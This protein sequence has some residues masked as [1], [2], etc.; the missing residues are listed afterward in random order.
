LYYTRAC[1]LQCYIHLELLLIMVKVH[2]C[3]LIAFGLYTSV[4]CVPE[5]H[6]LGY[7]LK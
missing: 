6:V 4:A 7:S 1:I 3:L 2:V 5:Y